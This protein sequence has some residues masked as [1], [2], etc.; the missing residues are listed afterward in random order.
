M[1]MLCNVDQLA[2]LKA[3]E[4]LLDIGRK[5]S[6]WLTD[7]VDNGDFIEFRT[8]VSMKGPDEQVA[9]IRS[10]AKACGIDACPLADSIQAEPTGVLVP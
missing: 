8:L 6:T 2:S 3:E 10:Q 4:D 9:E 1:K 5:R 7:Q